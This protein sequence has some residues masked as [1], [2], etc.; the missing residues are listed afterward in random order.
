M[1]VR[2]D[3]AAWDIGGRV[4]QAPGRPLVMG[5]VNLSPDSFHPGSRRLAPEAAAD[6]AL[7]MF[8][9]GADLVDLG[10]ESSRPGSE[11]VGTAEELRRLLPALAEIRARTDRPVSVDTT[12]AETAR[13]ALDAGADAVNDITAGTHDPEM[14]AL[15][16]GY[17][18]G[19]VLMHM[20]GTP[21][22][23]QHDP[24][25]DDVVAEVGD[26]LA[27]R[28]AAAEDAGVARERIVVDPGIGFG[29]TLGH[30]LRLL[31]ALPAVAGD[32]SLLV[33][34]SR[35]R[36]IE[37]LTGAPVQAR[38][39]GSLAAAALAQRAGAAVVRVH[40]VAETVQFL[41]V[42]AAID[43]ETHTAD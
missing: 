9:A 20:R 3:A 39:P 16:A 2:R 29:K 25:Y 40:D 24:H 38:L 8:A 21:A 42:L 36:F 11:P 30:N 43:A 1:S 7:A 17:G 31:A 33:G 10:A 12:R 37:F 22:T 23:M 4:L 13:A 14:L 26:Y 32:R 5:I 34:A 35:K 19:L 41:K 6:T 18:C 28:A 27:V 15:A